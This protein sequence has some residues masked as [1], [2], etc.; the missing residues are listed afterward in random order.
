MNPATDSSRPFVSV[1]E[2]QCH[3]GLALLPVAWDDRVYVVCLAATD[4]GVCF[5]A[6]AL[7]NALGQYCLN[8]VVLV[9]MQGTSAKSFIPKEWMLF[10]LPPCSLKGL[11][12]CQTIQGASSSVALDLVALDHVRQME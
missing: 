4:P 2:A 5:S 10:H 12:E 6:D 1:V 3:F 8:W 9:D 7:R 11:R